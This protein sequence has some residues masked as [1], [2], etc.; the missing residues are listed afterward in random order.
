MAC[1]I[2]QLRAPIRGRA[3]IIRYVVRGAADKLIWADDLD[4]LRA[5][6]PKPEDLP[7]DV[8]FSTIRH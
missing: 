5:Y 7:P 1:L 3:G 2:A 6:L 8:P 4:E